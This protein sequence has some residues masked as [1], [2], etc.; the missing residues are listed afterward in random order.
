MVLQLKLKQIICIFLGFIILMEKKITNSILS[1]K[2]RCLVRFAV[3]KL[4]LYH[5]IDEVIYYYS[6]H[7]REND[8]VA[9]E[10][11]DPDSITIKSEV[12]LRIY[13]ELKRWLIK[14]LDEGLM[15]RQVFK[16]HKKVW[17][18]KK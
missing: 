5:H 15:A 11:M 4:Q 17:L 7:T 18:D 13:E 12:A 2:K 3:R 10:V 14:H 8:E 6:E 16:E 1:I 9:H